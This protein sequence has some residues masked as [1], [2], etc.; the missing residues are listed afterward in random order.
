MTPS[1][2]QFEYGQTRLP[3]MPKNVGLEIKVAKARAV[4][5]EDA[6]QAIVFILCVP[7]PTSLFH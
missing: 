7:K 1:T 5:P 2:N 4:V 3:D 6:P